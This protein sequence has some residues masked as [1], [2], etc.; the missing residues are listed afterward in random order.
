M[1]TEMLSVPLSIVADTVIIDQGTNLVSIIN[2]FE[3]F[4]SPSLPIV[5]PSLT[6]FFLIKRETTDQEICQA[7]IVFSSNGKEI[8]KLPIELNFQGRPTLRQVVRFGNYLV[9]E[10]G[11][12]AVAMMIEGEQKSL[13]EIPISIV[14]QPQPK[15]T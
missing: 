15:T 13:Y 14:G 8:Q 4:N 1:A 2:I 3:E 10:P 7:T 11:K 12:L 9:K 5:I 6:V